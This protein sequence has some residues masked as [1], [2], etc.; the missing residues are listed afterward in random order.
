MGFGLRWRGR[1][2][3]RSASF[4]FRLLFELG[5]VWGEESVGWVRVKLERRGGRTGVEEGSFA[6]V[7][8][9]EVVVLVEGVLGCVKRFLAWGCEIYGAGLLC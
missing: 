9:P 2:T 4:C 3:S 5:G 8:F 6:S 7:G 1:E